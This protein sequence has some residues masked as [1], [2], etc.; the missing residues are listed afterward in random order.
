V[1]IPSLANYARDVDYD[2]YYSYPWEYIADMLGDVN[3]TPYAYLEG[4]QE[5]AQS[6]W[7][8]T[9]DYAGVYPYG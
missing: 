6:Y 4:S 2:I 8:F 1:V 3:R 9:Y 5:R 7:Q